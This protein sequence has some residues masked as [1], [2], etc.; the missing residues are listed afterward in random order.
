MG[1]KKKIGLALGSGGARGLAHIGVLKVLEKNNIKIDFIAG[2]SIGALIGSFYAAGLSAKQIEKIALKTNWSRLFSLIDIN[3]KQGIIGG[4]KV[5]NFIIENIGSIK[6]KD[7]KIPL[8]VVAT[9]FKN[10]ETVYFNQGDVTSAVKASISM[11]L[12]FSPVEK[13]NKL[14]IDGGFSMPVPVEAVK[15]MGADF[16]IAVNLDGGYF[17]QEQ[18]D[19]KKL[20]LYQIANTSINIVRYNLA[21]LNVKD[22]DLNICPTIGN[23]NW[24]KFTDGKKV[25]IAGEKA[26]NKKIKEIK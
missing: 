5:K 2:S 13:D 23:I 15:K 24:G 19:Y 12:V 20:T 25:I 1:K 4:E 10:G 26:M 3:L 6:F 11:P 14:L 9:D 16:I 8:T 7:L 18:V 21:A 17:Q 22:A